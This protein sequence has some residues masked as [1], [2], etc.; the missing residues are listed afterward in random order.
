MPALSPLAVKDCDG[1]GEIVSGDQQHRN[2]SSGQVGKRLQ[3]LV[4]EWIDDCNSEAAVFDA[5]RQNSTASNELRTN[6]L[7]QDRS[8]W[9]VARRCD[10]RAEMTRQCPQKGR[11]RHEPKFGDH[12]VEPLA[13]CGSSSSGPIETSGVKKVRLDQSSTERLGEILLLRRR[14]EPNRLRQFRQRCHGLS[15]QSVQKPLECSCP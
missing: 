1:A 5:K 9:H 7:W 13:G 15:L 10:R 8:R 11:V 3:G 2:V 14:L 6:T 4:V 12:M